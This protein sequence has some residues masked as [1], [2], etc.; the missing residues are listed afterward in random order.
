[1]ANPRGFRA[2]S[3]NS[4]PGV[5][6]EKRTKAGVFSPTLDKKL[7]FYSNI[8]IVRV[9]L[10]S[11]YSYRKSCDIFCALKETEGARSARM[12]H[13]LEVLGSVEGL[14]FS[15]SCQTRHQGKLSSGLRTGAG[16]YH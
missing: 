2:S 5:T 11:E 16:R 14:L 15:I 1:M 9:C 3:G 8:N 4:R 7:A 6:V 10:K 12:D 13:A